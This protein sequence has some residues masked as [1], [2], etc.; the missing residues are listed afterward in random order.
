MTVFTSSEMQAPNI[1]IKD[2]AAC[3]PAP[4]CNIAAEKE[5]KRHRCIVCLKDFKCPFSLK[6]HMSIHTGVLTARIQRKRERC[7]EC[8]VCEKRFSSPSAMKD[9]MNVHTGMCKY[10]C[11]ICGENFFLHRSFQLHGLTH[12]MDRP[13]KCKLCTSTFKRSN[14]LTR[15]VLFVHEGKRKIKC[16]DCNRYYFPHEGSEVRHAMKYHVGENYRIDEKPFKCKLCD[17]QFIEH[18]SLRLHVDTVHLDT[19]PYLCT[20]CGKT[21]KTNVALEVH[22]LIHVE[23]K[24]VS[25][26]CKICQKMVKLNA[27]YTH[28]KSHEEKK[29]LCNFCGKRFS[30]KHQLTNHEKSHLGLKAHACDLCD[31]RFTLP[32]Q[33]RAHRKTHSEF[34]KQK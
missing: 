2:S 18:W 17:A 30:L 29:F 6:D 34:K 4:M 10:E 32:H 3:S 25:A 23:A 31:K 1:P 21:F 26:E 28:M 22:S 5:V 9:H 24:K 13:H 12:S 33:L 27:M 15:H 19:R 14:H 11:Q 20:V 7:H 8:L 16:S